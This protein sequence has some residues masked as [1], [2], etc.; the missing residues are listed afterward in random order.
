MNRMISASLAGALLVASAGIAL[1]AAAPAGTNATTPDRD[2]VEAARMTQSLN[3]LGAQGYGDFSNFRQDGKNFAATVTR[4][5]QQ[6]SVVVDPD[7]NRVTP[8][9]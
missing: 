2:S 6:L 5:G 1:A 8:Q 7:T 4:S 3:L 9:G